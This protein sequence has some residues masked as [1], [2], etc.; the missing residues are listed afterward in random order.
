MMKNVSIRLSER[1]VPAILITL[2]LLFTILFL[3]LPLASIFVEAFRSGAALYFASFKEEYAWSA[4]YLTILAAL[5]S[6]PLNVVFGVTAAWCI[7]K[8][9]F[10]GKNVLITLIDLPFAVSPVIAGLVFVLAFGRQSSLGA[11][12]IEHNLKIIFATPGVILATIFVTVPF[13]ARELIPLMQEQ[14]TLEEEAAVALGANGWHVFWRVTLPNIKWGLLYGVI[15]CNARAMG[16][17]GAV[18]VV[19][20]HIRGSTNTMPLYIETL[21]AGYDAV[22]AFS[23]ATILAALALITLIAKSIVEWKVK[24]ERD[25]IS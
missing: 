22:S 5:I 25:R 15:L 19:S 9:N 23:I 4:I 20:G 10:W 18:S 8:F 1:I 2:T 11:W 6:V 21:Y 3:V 17:F 13:V 14:G 12:L 7:T 24:R 16:E